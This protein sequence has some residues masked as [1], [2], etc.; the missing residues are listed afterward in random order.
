MKKNIRKFS[1]LAIKMAIAA[2][3]LAWV[4]AKVHWHDYV[5]SRDG[6][7]TYSVLDVREAA[8]GLPQQLDVR[9]GSIFNGESAIRNATD[10]KPISDDEPDKV[11]RKGFASSLASLKVPLLVCAMGGFLLSLLIV[12][13]R[14]WMLLRIQRIRL[15]LWEVIRLTFLGQFFNAVVPGTVGGDLI[16]AYYVSKHTDRKAAALVSIFVDRVMGLTELVLLAAVMLIIVWATGLEGLSNIRTPAI[17]V[18]VVMVVVVV[19][20]AMLLSARFRRMFHIQKLYQRLPIAKSLAAAGDA[21]NLYRKR[22]AYLIRA[23]AITFGAHIAWVGAIGLIGKSLG[24]QIP[25]YNYFVYIP[26]IYIIGAVPL[27]PGGVGLIEKFYLV[28]FVSALVTPSEVLALALLAR[29][30]PI[31][32]GLPGAV[33]AIT[34]PKL[35][36]ADQMQAELGLASE[37]KL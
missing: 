16:K 27:T 12:A 30:I 23:V 20:L 10:F 3:L 8:P 9:E 17:T 34:G 22:I 18:G 7:T 35:P 37:K 5:I 26:L 13:V 1:F 6:E 28:F 24:L 32:W 11:V 25:F 21:A 36:K 31:F 15:K 33:V 2:A 4:L 19:V 14:W 29:I